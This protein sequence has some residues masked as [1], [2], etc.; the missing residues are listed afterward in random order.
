MSEMIMPRDELKKNFAHIIGTCALSLDEED[1]RQAFEG[2]LNSYPAIHE[3][4]LRGNKEKDSIQEAEH[5]AGADGTDEY[6]KEITTP[7][8]EREPDDDAP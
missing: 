8:E 3:Q 1:I 7:E 2:A 5:R 4:T 6:F